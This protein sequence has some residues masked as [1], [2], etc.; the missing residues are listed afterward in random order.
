MM[1]CSLGDYVGS[2]NNMSILCIFWP[3]TLICPTQSVVNHS[4]GQMSHHTVSSLIALF[5]MQ[6]HAEQSQWCMGT[7]LTRLQALNMAHLSSFID[8]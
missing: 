2:N 4:S 7:F 1:S 8:E 5:I 3:M 6:H